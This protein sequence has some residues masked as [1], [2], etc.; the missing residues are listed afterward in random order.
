MPE[1][2]LAGL[3]GIFNGLGTDRRGARAKTLTPVSECARL[4]HSGRIER[5]VSRMEYFGF[6]PVAFSQADPSTAQRN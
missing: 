3:S 4:A 6:Q 2:G 1:R 5:I